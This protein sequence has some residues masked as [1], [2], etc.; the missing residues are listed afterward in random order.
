MPYKD[1]REFIRRLEE[2]DEVSRVK[3]EVDLNYEVGAICSKVMDMGGV[4]GSKALIFEKPKGYIIPLAVNLL[5][6]RKRYCM[7]IDTNPEE[8]DQEWAERTKNPLPPVMVEHGPCKENIFLGD[9]VDLFKLPIPIWNGKDGGPYI[10]LPHHISRD[11]ETGERNVAVYRAQVHDKTTIGIWANPSRHINIQWRKAHS[12]GESF[13][14][15]IAIGLDPSITLA[16]TAAFLQ[17]FDELAMAGALR[18]APVELVKCETIPLEVPAAAEWVLEGVIRPNALKRE[19][20]FGEAAGYYGESYDR[21]FI[22]VKAITHRNNP[23]HQACYVRRPPCETSILATPREAEII[24]Q[25]PLPGLVRFQHLEAASEVVGVASI[26][27]TFD[28]QGKMMGMAILGTPAAMVIKI[29]IVVDEDIDPSNLDDV[30][31]AVST[32]F[33]PDLDLEVLKDVPSYPLDPSMP[34][35][36]KRSGSN[37]AS[38]MLIDATKPVR[39]LFAEAV[40]PQKEAMYRVNREWAKYGIT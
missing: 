24:R 26:K 12:K 25:C 23:I 16:A 4:G 8:L 3:I 37:L 36:S 31:W 6:T 14:V 11:P 38:K 2:D 40:A 19:G 32:R 35:E 9:E 27:K 1:L 13:P 28:G 17:G 18:G 15:A 10:T 33:Q 34:M 21:E 39:H 22:E 30:I 7:A 20:P 29:L 5:S